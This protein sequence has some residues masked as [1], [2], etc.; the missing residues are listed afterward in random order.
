MESIAS[1]WTSE[2]GSFFHPRTTTLVLHENFVQSDFTCL[3]SIYVPLFLILEV[4]SIRNIFRGHIRETS[5]Y[6]QTLDQFSL[7]STFLKRG[8][9]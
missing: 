2:G 3:H 4:P 5:K 6:F 1:H 8:H 9:V 7:D